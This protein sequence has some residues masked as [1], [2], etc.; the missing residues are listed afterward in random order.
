MGVAASFPLEFRR[1]LRSR[2]PGNTS[3]CEL[4]I[5]NSRFCTFPAGHL[6]SAHM[7]DSVEDVF[8]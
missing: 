6:V 5:R 8:A 4:C 1:N 2:F 3:A 7:A